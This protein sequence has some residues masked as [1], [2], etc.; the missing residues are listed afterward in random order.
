MAEHTVLLVTPPQKTSVPPQQIPTFLPRAFLCLSFHCSSSSGLEIRS[1][2]CP[3]LMHLCSPGFVF[4]SGRW[5]HKHKIHSFPS[6]PF[7]S[8]RFSPHCVCSLWK[9]TDRPKYKPTSS[10]LLFPPL[11]FLRV[12][13]SERNKS[14]SVFL[15][16]LLRPWTHW[17]HLFQSIK[18]CRDLFSG[19]EANWHYL[20]MSDD[21]CVS[22]PPS[23]R[24]PRSSPVGS[25]PVVLTRPCS[26]PAR[27]EMSLPSNQGAFLS[28]K[29][30][31]VGLSFH[32]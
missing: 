1:P 15:A 8:S 3:H 30:A 10:A 31:A 18:Q 4:G 24:H 19:P 28:C 32:R 5:E 12:H 26:L 22:N 27:Q 23:L 6:I 9:S 11:L 17:R 20:A 2:P 29:Q 13:R 14:R 25:S 21:W 16:L 7:I